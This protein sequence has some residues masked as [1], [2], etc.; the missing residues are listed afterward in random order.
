MGCEDPKVKGRKGQEKQFPGSPENSIKANHLGRNPHCSSGRRRG[1]GFSFSSNI[2][3]HS[4]GLLAL[5]SLPLPP[6]SLVLFFTPP[7]DCSGGLGPCVC[8]GWRV[9]EQVAAPLL[10]QSQTFHHVSH[11]VPGRQHEPRRPSFCLSLHIWIA[12]C[13][14]GSCTGLR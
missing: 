13:K 2:F 1:H 8:W 12:V 9:C 14:H 4:L 6:G 10:L 5:H 11:S 3:F 7:L